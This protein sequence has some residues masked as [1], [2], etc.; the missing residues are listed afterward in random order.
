MG[1]NDG[2][3]IG[4][5]VSRSRTEDRSHFSLLQHPVGKLEYWLD[6]V[7]FPMPDPIVEEISTQPLEAYFMAFTSE[8]DADA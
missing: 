7:E 5:Q 1:L 8:D 6:Q 4:V 3:R 2:N